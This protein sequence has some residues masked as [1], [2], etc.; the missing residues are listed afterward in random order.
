MNVF[1]EGLPSALLI[2]STIAPKFFSYSALPIAASS[3]TTCFAVLACTTHS[4]PA[5]TLGRTSALRRSDA[6]GI[7]RRKA[8]FSSWDWSRM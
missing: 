4:L 1:V 5:L 6:S 7:P 3:S 2:R 8:T